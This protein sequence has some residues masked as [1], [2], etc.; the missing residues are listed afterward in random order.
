MRSML[1]SLR[2]LCISIVALLLL[3]VWLSTVFIIIII[4]CL[5]TEPRCSLLR[6]K[7]SYRVF[8]IA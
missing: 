3:Q 4:I 7:V 5:T 8:L 6:P 2:R 1:A